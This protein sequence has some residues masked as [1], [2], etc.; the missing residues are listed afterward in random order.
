V[1]TL[2]P[3]PI[4]TQ[5]GDVPPAIDQAIT[6]AL[7]KNPNQR[8]PSVADFARA[9]RSG[10]TWSEREAGG[11]FETQI[12][13]D[14]AGTALADRLGIESLAVRDASWRDA[15]ESDFR[16]SLSSSP[17]GLQS[18]VRPQVGNEPGAAAGERRTSLAKT[19]HPP[20][21]R[22]GL[23]IVLAALAAGA[24][25]AAVIVLIPRPAQENVSR[26]VVIEKQGV[27]SPRAEPAPSVAASPAPP[28]AASSEP[29]ETPSKEAKAPAATPGRAEARAADG[30][31][32]TLARAFQRQEGKIQSCFQRHAGESQ[33][34][35]NIAVRFQIDASGAVQ[36]AVVTPSS[37]AGTPLGQCL[38]TVARSTHFGPQPE[39]ISFSIPIAARVVRR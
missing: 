24:G 32:T 25:S 12:E 38:V 1:L 16:V 19:G 3:D 4:S 34:E 14:F 5:R 11:S 36:N 26:L 10:C 15:Q 30:R 28:V 7:S 39:G 20:G 29:T 35:P 22:L 37:V 9:I 21:R 23:W 18:G 8:F 27:E 13:R 31:G 6:R 33:R 2:E 17:P